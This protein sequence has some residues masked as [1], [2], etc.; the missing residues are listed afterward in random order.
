MTNDRIEA[1]RFKLRDNAKS[2]FKKIREKSKDM[3]VNDMRVKGLTIPTCLKTDFD[4]YYLCLLFGLADGR[5]G[6]VDNTSDFIDHFESNYKSVSRLLI[7]LLAMAE[8]SRQG[9]NF[10]S[11]SDVRE[12]MTKLIDTDQ[13]TS[14]SGYGLGRF[15]QYASGGFDV[16]TESFESQPYHIEIFLQAYIKLVKEKIAS[17]ED[18]L[19]F[20]TTES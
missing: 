4:I 15:N 17:N 20:S 16:L 6:D 2:W 10:E 18:W 7:A 5:I 19:T 9:F 14:L 11:K 13:S 1:S 12:I 3:T 8:I